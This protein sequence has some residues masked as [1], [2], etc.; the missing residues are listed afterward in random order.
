MYFDI[1]GGA[2]SA[3]VF[4]EMADEATVG[5]VQQL[6]N[7]EIFSDA[8]IRIMPDCHAGKGCV[9]G[10]TIAFKDAIV[11]NLVG[12]D[13]GCGMLACKIDGEVDLKI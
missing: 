10:T 3:R 2:T 4:T 1:F 11:P 12:V 5:Q 8:Q 6:C 13:I 9:V 7:L